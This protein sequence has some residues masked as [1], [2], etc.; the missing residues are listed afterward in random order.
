MAAPQ[1]RPTLRA[2]SGDSEP[3]RG[4]GAATPVT[5]AATSGDTKALL[6]ATRERIAR[7]V[8]D[9]GTPARDLAA[10][11]KRLVDVAREIES[12]SAREAE[13]RARAEKDRNRQVNNDDRFDPEA[14]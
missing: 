1:K 14:I 7:A 11:T 2:V 10:L 8:D 12:I 13:E 5:D 4:S 6:V 9:P 3:D